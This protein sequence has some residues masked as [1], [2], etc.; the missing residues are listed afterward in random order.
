MGQ[1][2]D[3]LIIGAGVAGLSAGIYARMNGLDVTIY[4]MHRIPGGLCTSW[5]RRGF[6][7]DG[8]VRYLANVNPDT[9]GY[10]LWEELGILEG[11]QFHFYNEFN[12]IEGSDGR[13]LHIYT[14]LD[15]FENHLLTLSPQD[16]RVIRDFIG[17]IQ[18]FRRL[19][20]PVDLTAED[21]LELA[22]MGREMVPVLLPTLR[23][24]V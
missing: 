6:V 21:A 7:F 11:T 19:E 5:R 15:R 23:W 22:Q 9:K 2:P 16:R 3:I 20:L 24:A 1:K 12:C 8:A 4:E 13:Q 14:D 10:Q 18:D 17:G